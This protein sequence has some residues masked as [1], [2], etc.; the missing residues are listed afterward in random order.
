MLFFKNL[1][2]YKKFYKK[3]TKSIQKEINFKNILRY[4]Q[5]Y[6]IHFIHLLLF[7]PTTITSYCI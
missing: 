2:T 1:K 6:N 7:L 3:I 4:N 5:I